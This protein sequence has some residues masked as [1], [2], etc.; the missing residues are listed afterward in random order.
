M[1]LLLDA[2]VV[3]MSSSS[4]R[5]R[6]RAVARPI[7]RA[8]HLFEEGGIRT[9]SVSMGENF[10]FASRS[11]EGGLVVRRAWRGQVGEWRR[12]IGR[13]GVRLG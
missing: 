2:L 11:W 10:A 8:L 1:R 6:V 4:M 7:M 5:H 12:S 3:K 13:R 9:A